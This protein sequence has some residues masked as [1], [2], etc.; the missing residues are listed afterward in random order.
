MTILA[1]ETSTEFCSVALA[2]DNQIV[3]EEK[4]APRQHTELILPMVES[5]LNEA[6]LSLHELDAIAYGKGPGSFTGVR[7]AAG[8]TQGLAY[9]ASIPVIAVSSLA[10]LALAVI[11]Q[12]TNIAVATDAR[13]GEIYHAAFANVNS[14]DDLVRV[15]EVLI[16]PADLT[17]DDNSPWLAVG[18]GWKNYH[19][20]LAR[21]YPELCQES[22][23]NLLPSARHILPIAEV[24]YS[25]RQLLTAK[26]AMPLYLRSNVTG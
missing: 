11:D 15:N 9:S 23:C 26:Q 3:V 21:R 22:L 5:V 12:S 4:L 14:A 25:K 13:M 6:S 20:I 7:L 1:I 18:N 16:H 10:A 24:M 19:D 17:L 8:V 2:I